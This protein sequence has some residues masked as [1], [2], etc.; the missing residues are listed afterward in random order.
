MN[1]MLGFPQACT[2]LATV[3]F[4]CLCRYFNCPFVNKNNQILTQG[5]LHFI[6]APIF[7]R[8]LC[9][10]LHTAYGAHVYVTATR[11]KKNHWQIQLYLE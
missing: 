5:I 3:L 7:I 6:L 8:S 2:Q 9:R 11:V 1:A 10:L 4:M